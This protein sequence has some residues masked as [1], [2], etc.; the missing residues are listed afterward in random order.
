MLRT[1]VTAM[2]RVGA[3]LLMLGLAGVGCTSSVQEPGSTLHVYA[4]AS[5]QGP[6]EQLAAGFED[7]HQGVAVQLLFTGSADAVAQIK[8][9]APADV[10]AT[11]DT[12]TM[13]TLVDAD[14][15]ATT[16]RTFATNTLQLVASADVAPR[17]DGWSVI[18]QGGALVVCA[19]VV[20]CGAATAAL[21]E[22]RRI[23]LRPVSEEQSV[24][25]VLAKVTSGSADLGIVYRTD[26]QRAGSAVRGIDLPGADAVVNEYPIAQVKDAAEEGLA[27][28]F[29][30]LVLSEAGRDLLDSAG[31]GAP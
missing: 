13:G 12:V 1:R 8:A 24:T 7:E 11:A 22:R 25:D 16:P 29:V 6:F 17:D 21:A 31:F 2:R 23:D 28:D 5:L 15:V 27:G 30:Q 3:V 26:V 10:V 20:P 14:L 18:A 19:P 9:G 4:A